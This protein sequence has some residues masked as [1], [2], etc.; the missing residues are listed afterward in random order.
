M[1]GLGYK[2]RLLKLL[3]DVHLAKHSA[4]LCFEFF[5]FEVV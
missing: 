4:R 3:K 1:Y 5:G 2:V